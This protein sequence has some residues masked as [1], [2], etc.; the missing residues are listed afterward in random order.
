MTITQNWA[1]KQRAN[2]FKD[3]DDTKR[4]FD[5]DEAQRPKKPEEVNKNA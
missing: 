3:E 1:N 2:S 5:E 4:K